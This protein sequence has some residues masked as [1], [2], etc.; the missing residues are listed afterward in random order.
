MTA[1]RYVDDA[2]AWRILIAAA[3]V[4]VQRP[5]RSADQVFRVAANRAFKARFPKS[6]GEDHQRPFLHLVTE[7]RVWF[8]YGAGARIARAPA[9]KAAIDACAALLGPEPPPPPPATTPA[10]H[11]YWLEDEG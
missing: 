11:R 10:G 6:A 3:R 8:G 7:G 2:E 5:T 9:L 4:A 1:P